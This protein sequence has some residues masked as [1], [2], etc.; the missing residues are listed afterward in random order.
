MRG[1]PPCTWPGRPGSTGTGAAGPVLWLSGLNIPDGV[2]VQVQAA[3]FPI[4]FQGKAPGRT[5]DKDPSA[6]SLAREHGGDFSLGGRQGVG[7]LRWS[8]GWDRSAELHS[9]LPFTQTGVGAFPPWDKELA[10]GPVSGSV[11][12]ISQPVVRSMVKHTVEA[13]ATEV[14]DS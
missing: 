13:H 3:L 2:P 1:E 5:A 9:L 12:C 14:A 8:Q 4:Q 6:W 7:L 10:Q 11:Q